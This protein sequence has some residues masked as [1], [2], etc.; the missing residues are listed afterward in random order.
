MRDA[1]PNR[2]ETAGR[3]GIPQ[4]ISMCGL[5]HITPSRTMVKPKHRKRRKYDL[6]AFRT[7]IRMTP[8]E[9]REVSGI[10][11]GK[12]NRSTG[13]VKVL[14]PLRG[15]SSV[16]SPDSPTYDPKEDTIFVKELRGRL[17]DGIEIIQVD[18]N[19]EDPEFAR[20]VAS[21]ASSLFQKKTL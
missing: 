7:W 16:D 20:A 15:W 17:R 19:M 18:A 13:P 1:G 14:V 9:L 3:L 10:F 12:L 8:K 21:T 2:M 5:N 4:V 6:D 11:A